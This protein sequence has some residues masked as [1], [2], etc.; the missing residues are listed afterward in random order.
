LVEK[1]Q[2]PVDGIVVG[3]GDQ[4]HAA[5]LGEPV[6]INW[7]RVTVPAAQESQVLR[8]PGMARVAM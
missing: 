1:F 2:T 5:V 6:D 7:T 8:V 3:D 4:V